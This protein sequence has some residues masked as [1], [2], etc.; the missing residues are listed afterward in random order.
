[1]K[2]RDLRTTVAVAVA[3][4][5]AAQMGIATAAPQ[6]LHCILTRSDGA[7]YTITIQGVQFA[8]TIARRPAGAQ[9]IDR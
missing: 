7:R 9:R 5:V 8:E 6:Q 4:L 1:M 3:G 2:A